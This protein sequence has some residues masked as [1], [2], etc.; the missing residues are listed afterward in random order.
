MHSED[1]LNEWGYKLLNTQ[2]PQHAI[3]IFKLNAVL[4]P[5]SA[6]VYDSL[7]DAYERAGEKTLAIQYYRKCLEIASNKTHA[8]TRLRVLTAQ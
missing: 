7:A 6:N 8:Q 1:D 4:H 3:A 2:N 5:E